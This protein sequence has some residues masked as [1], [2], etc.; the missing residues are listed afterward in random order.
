M[1][2]LLIALTLM[3]AVAGAAGHWASRKQRR[4]AAGDD[5]HEPTKERHARDHRQ[6]A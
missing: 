4:L 2:S 1:I 6:R 3:L 5:H